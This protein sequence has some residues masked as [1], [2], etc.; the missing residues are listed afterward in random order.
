[1]KT[2]KVQGHNIEVVLGG[3]DPERPGQYLG[4]TIDSDLVPQH[5]DSIDLVAA[6]TAV[7]SLILSQACAGIDIE[8]PAYAEALESTLDAI[9]NNYG[10]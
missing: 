7:E 9:D 10:D 5:T 4:G 2:V 1:M 6:M 3:P 8:T